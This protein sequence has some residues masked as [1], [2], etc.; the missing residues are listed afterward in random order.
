MGITTPQQKRSE[1]TLARILDACDEL[2]NTRGFDEISMQDIAK[3]AGVSVGNLYNRFSDKEQLVSHLI[4]RR[5]QQVR[6]RVTAAMLCEDGV[7][8]ARERLTAVVRG[9]REGLA[10]SRPLLVAAARRIAAG[11]ETDAE[12]RS[13]SEQ[14][15]EELADWVGEARA[16]LD[17]KRCRFAVATIAWALQFDVLYGAPTRIFGA[18]LEDALVDQALGYLTARRG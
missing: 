16:D 1:A 9:L 3:T 11:H 18:G 17:A 5:R 6:E 7:D 10:L 8:G 14:L 2:A 4:T 12:V 15:I 13:G